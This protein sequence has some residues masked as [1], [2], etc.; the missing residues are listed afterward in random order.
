MTDYTDLINEFG[1]KGTTAN[2]VVTPHADLINEFG[3][4]D[5]KAAPPAAQSQDGSVYTSTSD[6]SNVPQNYAPAG[7]PVNGVQEYRDPNVARTPTPEPPTDISKLPVIRKGIEGF[8]NASDLASSGYSDIAR[9]S[10]ASGVGKV[11]LG[12][13]SQLLNATGISPLIEEGTDQLGKLTGNPEFA[14]RASLVATSGLPIAKTG[15]VIASTM[16]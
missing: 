4:G 1:S 11:V 16:P 2:T 3:S 14:S 5:V 15:S 12:H 10:P 6:A 9:N 7:A 8:K 13:A